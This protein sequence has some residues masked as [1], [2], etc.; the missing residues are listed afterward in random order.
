MAI[1]GKT[2]WICAPSALGL[3]RCFTGGRYWTLKFMCGSCGCSSIV[4]HNDDKD[5]H[6]CPVCTA[7]N[8][9]DYYDWYQL[10]EL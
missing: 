3:L 10:N 4:Q 2:K 1:K 7:V 8:I 9:L 5:W 6:K